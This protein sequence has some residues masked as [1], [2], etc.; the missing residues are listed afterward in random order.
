VAG[1]AALI[2]ACASCAS[3][4]KRA[5]QDASYRAKFEK[6]CSIRMTE[7]DAGKAEVTRQ[8]FLP[9]TTVDLVVKYFTRGEKLRLR[10]QNDQGETVN[11]S[12]R[13]ALIRMPLSGPPQSG[14][15]VIFMQTTSG[16]R[17]ELP[18]QYYSRGDN[19]V[20]MSR[21]GQ[22]TTASTG[23]VQDWA[24]FDCPTA[25]GRYTAVLDRVDRPDMERLKAYPF[26]VVATL[27][28]EEDRERPTKH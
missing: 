20:L 5:Q 10:L 24:R 17:Q 11:V 19:A 18:L 25:I 21:T 4:E 1:F 23:F 7:A 15:P 6:N 22:G 13:L 2:A 16:I 3:P 12:G 28:P 27:P 26:S 14:Y 9:G 8:H